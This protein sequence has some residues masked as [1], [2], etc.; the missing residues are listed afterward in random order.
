M[1]AKPYAVQSSCLDILHYHHIGIYCVSIFLT[2]LVKSC[3]VHRSLLHFF[4]DCC[5]A[6]LS[7]PRHTVE[8]NHIN[9]DGEDRKISQE[10]CGSLPC[11]FASTDRRAYGDG[12]GP[13]IQIYFG[14]GPHPVTVAFSPFVEIPYWIRN[15]IGGRCY[16]EG[17]T[18]TVMT[19]STITYLIGNLYKPSCATVTGWGPHPRYT[20]QWS[21]ESQ[22]CWRLELW[23]RIDLWE[24]LSQEVQIQEGN[25]STFP[26][27]LSSPKLFFV[28]PNLICGII[29]SKY[30]YISFTE[31]TLQKNYWFHLVPYPFHDSWLFK[32]A[33][34]FVGDLK[35]FEMH[36]DFYICKP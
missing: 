8:G 19:T 28:F 12:L 22:T 15:N 23:R 11:S 36:C 30:L 6:L 5:V 24:K 34:S 31:L 9:F 2:I 1:A 27:Q 10:D 32:V 18:P 3:Q 13:G 20:Q 35:T 33:L 29:H 26:I 17:G 25:V 14:C 16:W 21:V 4:G 7:G